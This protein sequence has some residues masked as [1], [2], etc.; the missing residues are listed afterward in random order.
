MTSWALSSAIAQ[1]KPS[2]SSQ[3]SRPVV[4]IHPGES[5]TNHSD[6][7][8]YALPRYRAQRLLRDAIL[9]DS[10]QQIASRSIADLEQRANELGRERSVWKTAAIVEGVLAAIGMVLLLFH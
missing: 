9:S 2:D 8:Y 6:S 4:V 7:S 3:V 5:F 1:E 10:I